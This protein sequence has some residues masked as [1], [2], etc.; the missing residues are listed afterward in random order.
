MNVVLEGYM[1]TKKPKKIPEQAVPVVKSLADNIK[2]YMTDE[3]RSDLTTDIVVRGVIKTSYPTYKIPRSYLRLN[4]YNGRFTEQL[5]NLKNERDMAKTAKDE[6]G[7]DASQID[8][9]NFKMEKTAD[10]EAVPGKNDPDYELGGDVYQIR[11]MIKGK[12]VGMIKDDSEKQKEFKDLADAMRDHI[13][14]AKGGSGQKVAGIITADGIYING[15]RRECVLEE[16]N[17]VAVDQS[18]SSVGNF[19]DMIVAVCPETITQSDIGYMELREQWS[20]DTT[21]AFPPMAL[22]KRLKELYDSQAAVDGITPKRINQPWN[23]TI[24]ARIAKYA[25]GRKPDEIIEYLDMYE[26]AL[27]VLDQIWKLMGF[28]VRKMI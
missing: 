1:A 18:L 12:S 5:A 23:K 25:G 13:I 11:Q 22:A 24:L 16:F 3:Y 17:Q 19:D 20:I 10:N 14:N 27:L 8:P 6:A 28:N 21:A 26:F 2:R 4:P 7:E 15:N 9:N